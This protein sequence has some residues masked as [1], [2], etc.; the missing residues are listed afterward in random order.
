MKS[1]FRQTRTL[2]LLGLAL[3]VAAAVGLLA[4]P[5]DA[6]LGRHAT[7]NPPGKTGKTGNTAS[8]R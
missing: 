3:A 8:P 2:L 5:D 1:W 4:L 7:S 6:L